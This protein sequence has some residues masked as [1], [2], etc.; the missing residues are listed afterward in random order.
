[1][2]QIK[3]YRNTEL[4]DSLR[5]SVFNANDRI[6]FELAYIKKMKAQL[7]TEI[8]NMHFSKINTVG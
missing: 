4:S 1:M 6:S 2:I 3:N 8:L 7:L 5:D